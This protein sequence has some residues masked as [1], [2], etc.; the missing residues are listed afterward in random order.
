VFRSG[1]KKVQDNGGGQH[2]ETQPPQV[3]Q[4]KAP[5]HAQPDAAALIQLRSVEKIYQT[6]A[7]DFPALKGISA[8]FYPGEFVGI[9][10]KSG[11]GK[12]TLLNMITGV[13]EITSG[14][15]IVRASNG[16]G[17]SS[18]EEIS[19]HHLGENEQAL[20]RG[21]NLGIVHQSFQLLPMLNL[22]E[23]VILPMDFCGI[24]RSGES[25]R[26]ALELLGMVGLEQHAYKLPA[27]I[28]GGQ[29]QR[30]AIARA[31]IN[32]PPILVADE[33]TGSLDTVTAETIFEIFEQ[34]I[35]Q[36][37][38]ILMVTHDNSLGPRFSRRILIEDGMLIS[39]SRAQALLQA[40]SHDG[41]GS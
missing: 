34:L 31:L 12:S 19:V 36:G 2:V 40:A 6:T 13:D 32:D 29:K 30:V 5:S 11:A 25:E 20:W 1:R 21:L 37:K 27:A 35:E 17:S 18:K 3:S 16:N 33:P 38:T 14:Q 39:D 9:I 26:R 22:V 10:G 28:S 15:V 8:Q 7:G 41:K 23:N 4:P 24:Y